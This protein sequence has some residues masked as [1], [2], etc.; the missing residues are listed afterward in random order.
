MYLPIIFKVGSARERK[1]WIEAFTKTIAALAKHE[2][3][4]KAFDSLHHTS[5]KPP[6]GGGRSRPTS[7]IAAAGRVE[8]KR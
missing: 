7:I 6:G 1:A 2:L 3:E 4:A 5:N 8:M